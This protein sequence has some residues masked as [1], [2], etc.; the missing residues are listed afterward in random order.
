MT[1]PEFIRLHNLSPAEIKVL[2]LLKDGAPNRVAAEKLF[3]VEKTIK[4]HATNI[5]KKCKLSGKKDLVI[6]MAGLEW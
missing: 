6:K 5:Y 4:F 3:V 1:F 2:K